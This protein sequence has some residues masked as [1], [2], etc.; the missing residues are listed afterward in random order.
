MIVRDI[1]SALPVEVAAGSDGLDRDVKGGYAADLMSLVLVRAREGDAWLTLNAHPNV[2][3]I[4]NLLDLACVII[5]EGPRLDDDTV[6]RANEKAIPILVTND[7]TFA[8]ATKLG[9]MGI[10]GDR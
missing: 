7:T 9:G 6:A 3:A 5:T 2:V 4:A 8:I 10:A 1:V